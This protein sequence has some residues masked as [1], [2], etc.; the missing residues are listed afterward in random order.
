MQ[1]IIKSITEHPEMFLIIAGVILLIILV[2][3]VRKLFRKP[4]YNVEE[5]QDTIESDSNQENEELSENEN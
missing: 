5:Y 4:K 3:L 1:N 2:L